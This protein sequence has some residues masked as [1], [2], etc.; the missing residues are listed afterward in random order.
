M[1]TLVLLYAVHYYLVYVY[2]CTVNMLQ[3]ELVRLILESRQRVFPFSIAVI[4]EGAVSSQLM[5]RIYTTQSS[6]YSMIW[7]EVYNHDIFSGH[8]RNG[9]P[10]MGVNWRKILRL[11]KQIILTPALMKVWILRWPPPKWRYC[12]LGVI[13]FTFQPPSL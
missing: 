2:I 10:C 6:S 3:T 1:K 7:G 8:L 11:K 13:F 4:I 9:F 12:C 5:K